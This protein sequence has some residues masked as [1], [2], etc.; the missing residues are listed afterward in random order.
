MGKFTQFIKQTVLICTK[1]NIYTLFLLFN[2]GKLGIQSLLVVTH[3]KEKLNSR[4]R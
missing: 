4:A 2:V 3:R 1:S